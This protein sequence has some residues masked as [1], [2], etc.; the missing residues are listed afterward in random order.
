MAALTFSELVDSVYK[1]PQVFTVGIHRCIL[2]PEEFF[3]AVKEKMNI[4]Q[5]HFRIQKDN[6]VSFVFETIKKIDCHNKTQRRNDQTHLVSL[7]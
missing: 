7:K 5:K 2:S 6:D 1:L 4:M 3:K